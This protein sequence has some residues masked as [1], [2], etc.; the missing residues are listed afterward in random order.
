LTFSTLVCDVDGAGLLNKKVL[1]TEL[2]AGLGGGVWVL[3]QGERDERGS[4]GVV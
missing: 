4:M 1:G 3:M 2:L